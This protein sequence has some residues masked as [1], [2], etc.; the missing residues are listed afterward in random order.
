MT[1]LCFAA[2]GLAVLVCAAWLRERS[3]RERFPPISDAEFLARC[4]PGVD[5]VV[6]LR[7]RRIVAAHFAVEYE[8]VYPST[9]FVED[10]GAD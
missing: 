9:C 5:P 8:R 6:A 4:R 2:V 3:F 7:V 10:I 1:L